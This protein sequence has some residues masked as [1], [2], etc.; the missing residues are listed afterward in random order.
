MDDRP[1][2][3]IHD[4]GGTD[5]PV[6]RIGLEQ[7]FF[8]VGRTGELCDLADLFYAGVGR[9]HKRK[10]STRVASSQSA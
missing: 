5:V 3:D 8:L 9:Q 6:R 1:E 4:G 10:E 2:G 7:E